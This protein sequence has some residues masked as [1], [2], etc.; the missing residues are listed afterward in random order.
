VQYQAIREDKVMVS[1]RIKAHHAA[2]LFAGLAA[3]SNAFA[4]R[5]RLLPIGQDGTLA[6]IPAAFG[7]AN[8]KIS[9]SAPTSE[10]ASITSM[11]LT[12]GEKR[13][14]LPVCISGILRSRSMAEVKATGSWYHN[15]ARLPYYLNLTFFDPGYSDKNWANSGYTLLFNLR[16]GKLIKMEAQIVRDEGR[17]LQDSP[18]NLASRCTPAA[19]EAILDASVK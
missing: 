14:E 13:V 2:L 18:V 5:D 6:D 10:S 1:K 8:L 9:F 11:V 4:H 15:E 3:S 16:T 19:L 12:L 7:P 17:T